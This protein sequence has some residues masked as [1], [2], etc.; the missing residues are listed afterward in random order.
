MAAVMATLMPLGALAATGKP[1]EAAIASAFGK[2]DTDHDGKLSWPE[3]RTFGMTRAAFDQSN[4]DNNT[5]LDTKEFLAAITYQFDRANPD[6]HGTLDRR[7]A[8][9]AGV[10]SSKFFDAADPGKDGKLDLA[11]Y[12]QAFTMS[13]R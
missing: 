13:A 6:K 12:L 5:T 8:A 2:A 1:T 3:A 9:K 7:A 10:K 4:Q 11:G